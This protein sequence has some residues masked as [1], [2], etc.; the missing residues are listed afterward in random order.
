[1]SD[2]TTKHLPVDDYPYI[3][4]TG[5]VDTAIENADSIGGG[6]Y[7]VN[8]TGDVNDKPAVEIKQAALSGKQVCCYQERED[9]YY[10]GFLEKIFIDYDGFTLVFSIDELTENIV[11]YVYYIRHDDGDIDDVVT[12][13]VFDVQATIRE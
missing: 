9:G 3:C 6:V 10:Y 1:M 2:Y 11:K 13:A 5:V 7:W 4:Y 8:L 12:S